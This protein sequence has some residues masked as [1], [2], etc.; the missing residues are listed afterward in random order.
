M[1]KETNL[2]KEKIKELEK[3]N[4][5]LQTHQNYET[6]LIPTTISCLSLMSRLLLF[7]QTVR[8]LTGSDIRERNWQ[9][10]QY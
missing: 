4:L 8:L 3:E 10:T 1:D 9:E 6:F 2:L 7:I 5:L